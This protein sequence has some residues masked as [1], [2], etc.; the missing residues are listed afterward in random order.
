MNEIKSL[1]VSLSAIGEACRNFSARESAGFRR[2]HLKGALK[3]ANDRK[4]EAARVRALCN[5]KFGE[6]FV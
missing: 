2:A 5:R 3:S 1:S 4:N 6:A